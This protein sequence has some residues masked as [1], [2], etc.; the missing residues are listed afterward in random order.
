MGSKARWETVYIN[1][2]GTTISHP[3]VYHFNIIS[4][5][6][7]QREYKVYYEPKSNWRR[8]YFL[9]SL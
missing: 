1:E 7:S 9:H 3:K 4:K 2:K 5:F 6:T 8:A